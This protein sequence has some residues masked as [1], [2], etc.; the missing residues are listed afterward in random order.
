MNHA[1]IRLEA[2]MAYGSKEAVI[3]NLKDAG[4]NPEMI[5]C[6]LACLDSGQKEKMLQR[7]KQHR[8][9]LLEQLHQKQKQIDCLDYLVFQIGQ[10]SFL[11]ER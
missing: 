2:L 9:A 8:K 7:L 11:P 4:C 1:G 6:C 3:Q 5:E 10:C